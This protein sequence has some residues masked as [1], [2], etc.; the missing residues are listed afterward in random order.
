ML[1]TTV[2]NVVIGSKD[3]TMTEERGRKIAATADAA[4]RCWP[5]NSETRPAVPPDKED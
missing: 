4:A 1:C 3:T 5:G 2:Q